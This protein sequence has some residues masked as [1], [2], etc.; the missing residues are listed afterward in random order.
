MIKINRNQ[1]ELLSKQ[2]NSKH[3]YGNQDNILYPIFSHAYTNLLDI[4]RNSS[5]YE[6]AHWTNYID[7]WLLGRQTQNN[8]VGY[9]RGTIVFIDL[10]SGNFGHEPSFTHPAVVLAQSKDSIL[11]VPCS[12][13]KYGRGFPDII[14]ATPTDGFS[15]NTGIQTRSLRWISKNRVVSTIGKVSSSVLD[16]IDNELLKLIPS[17]TKQLLEKEQE[18]SEQKEEISTLY[19]RISSLEDELLAFKEKSKE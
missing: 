5:T 11:I 9:K 7:R 15:S 14:D 13:K 4:M 3:T 1:V 19:K 18:L 8:T 6:M 10:G 2:Q 16:S 12:S 17:H